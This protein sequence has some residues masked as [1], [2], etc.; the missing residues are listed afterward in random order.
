MRNNRFNTTTGCYAGVDP[1]GGSAMTHQNT[2]RFLVACYEG[3]W[4]KWT[5]DL[6]PV[7]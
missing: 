5:P 1:R 2:Q 4:M 3:G 7:E 6:G